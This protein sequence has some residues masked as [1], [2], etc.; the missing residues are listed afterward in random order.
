MT[1]LGRLEKIDL[2]DIWKHEAHQL[3]PWLLANSDVIAE[4][5]GIDLELS[6]AEHP[7]GSFSLD[8]LGRDLT[9]DCVLIVENQLTP[10]DHDHLGK[11]ITYAA[12][13]DAGTVIWLAPKFREEHREAL[14]L[15]NDLGSDRVRFFG[16]ELS[17]VRIGNSAP[18]PLVQLRAQPNDW[19][20]QVSASARATQA[21]GKAAM[22]REF[23]T[24]FLERVAVEHPTWTN[25][26]K[27]QTTSWLTMPCPFKG[28]SG[29]VSSFSQGGKVRVELYIDSVDGDTADAIYAELHA[30]RADLETTFGGPL[31]FEEL[32]DRRASRIAFYRDGDVSETDRHDEFIDWMFEEG[33]RLRAAVDAAAPAV[34]ASLTGS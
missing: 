23:W 15:L 3:T 19:H 18:A 27:P 2:R 12:G 24:K 28:G 32:A 33:A 1:E 16:V 14:D 9:N 8:L 5:L 20:A 13:T 10:T 31:Q 4:A 26:S 29:Y 6:V 17:A 21:T 25:A 7:V 11:L 34:L 30:R 22:Y